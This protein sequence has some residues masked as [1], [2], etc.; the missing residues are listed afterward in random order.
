MFDR[1]K[2][3]AESPEREAFRKAFDQL[4][5]TLREF[6]DLSQMVVGNAINM[7][8]SFFLQSHTSAAAFMRLRS[9]V[10]SFG[11]YSRVLTKA[12]SSRET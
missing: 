6:D 11:R 8:N 4:T 9:L 1:Y 5:R 12:R 10:H 3:E 7:A 2:S